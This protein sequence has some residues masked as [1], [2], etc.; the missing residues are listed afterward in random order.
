MQE[1][2]KLLMSSR[3]EQAAIR[4]GSA[5]CQQPFSSYESFPAGENTPLLGLQTGQVLSWLLFFHAGLNLACSSHDV[6]MYVSETLNNE[7]RKS[8]VAPGGA[9]L[10]SCLLAIFSNFIHRF[11]WSIFIHKVATIHTSLRSTWNGVSETKK[12]YLSLINLSDHM[13]PVTTLG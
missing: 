12:L 9:S 10:F 11:L 2:W 13:L 4:T 1:A 8:T 5:F 7:L 6:S 3:V